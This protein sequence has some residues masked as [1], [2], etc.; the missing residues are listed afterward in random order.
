MSTGVMEKRKGTTLGGPDV[1]VDTMGASS[2]LDENSPVDGPVAL[3]TP[4]PFATAPASL[5][6]QP[7]RHKRVAI[8]VVAI[9]T[10]VGIGLGVAYFIYASQFE[11]TD[12]AF[13]NGHVISIS[14]QIGARVLSVNVLDNQL[15][16]KGD[17]LVRLDPTD[18]QVALDQATATESAMQAKLEQARTQVVGAKAALQAASAGVAVAQ[19]N[20]ANA[21]A[22]Y[23]RVQTLSKGTPG[24]VSKQQFDSITAEQRSTDAQVDQ[25]KAK[26]AQATSDIATAE[27]SVQAAV[28]DVAKAA[29][30]RHKAE[31]NLSYCT[32]K[33]PEA[34]QI[35]KKSV[36]PGSYVETGQDLLAIVPADVWVVA[37]FK[38]TQLNDIHPGQPVSISVDA[39]PGMEL[40]GHVQSEQLGT[41]SRFSMLPAENATG[42]FVKVV[43]RVPV[44]IILDGN[45]GDDL[46]H[47]LA[48]GMSVEPQ[49]RIGG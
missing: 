27:A 9:L 40:H 14:P 15:V 37:N 5:K 7:K 18:Y 31:V 23:K 45:P 13:I 22:D 28:A 48:P 39:Y 3:G 16:K 2:L 17:V 4:P 6:P 47:P 21:Q 19:A 46:N 29:A 24:A 26:V 44:K 1:G 30:D 49:V 41:G 10:I 20:A 38:E 34:G 25:A 11:S 42:N 8:L 32:I 12:D 35:T 43:Q 33:A 36:E